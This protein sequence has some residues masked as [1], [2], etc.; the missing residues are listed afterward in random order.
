MYGNF[1]KFFFFVEDPT[2]EYKVSNLLMPDCIL[3]RFLNKQELPEDYSGTDSESLSIAS[4]LEIVDYNQ[5]MRETVLSA[6][7]I[8]QHIQKTQEGLTIRSKH[9]YCTKHET[10]LESLENLLVS[11]VKYPPDIIAS[12]KAVIPALKF[13]LTARTIIDSTVMKT[14]A[15]AW[16]SPFTDEITAAEMAKVEA[17]IQGNEKDLDEKLYSMDTENCVDMLECYNGIAKYLNYMD[18]PLDFKYRTETSPELYALNV[19][20]VNTMST[21]ILI[22]I[23][24]AVQTH[25]DD[26]SELEAAKFYVLDFEQDLDNVL[27][28][29]NCA[30]LQVMYVC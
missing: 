21:Q 13:M 29:V 22:D 23:I 10:L 30:G 20:D 9:L 12:I 11:N 16:R 7:Q 28:D 26:D 5:F 19:G 25:Q 8:K 17:V 4:L 27:K 2:F 18:H 3:R 6:Q 15:R 24:N 14:I 1:D